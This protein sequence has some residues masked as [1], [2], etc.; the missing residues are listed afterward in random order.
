MRSYVKLTYADTSSA[1]STSEPLDAAS[2]ARSGL[3]STDK[4]TAKAAQLERRSDK[5][6]HKARARTKM[7]PYSVLV[8]LPVE[9]ESWQSASRAVLIFLDK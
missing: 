9:V 8:S 1:R 2:D 6:M 4:D 5:R 3:F 7:K